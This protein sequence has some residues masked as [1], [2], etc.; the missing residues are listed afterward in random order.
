MTT[1][2]LEAR[3]EALESRYAHQEAA[4]EELTRTLLVT[5]QTVRAHEKTIERLELQVRALTPPDNAASQDER[6]PHY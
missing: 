1:Q 5:E 4:L 6:P 3:I 2:E